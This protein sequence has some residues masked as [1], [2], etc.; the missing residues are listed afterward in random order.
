MI[1]IVFCFAYAC[2]FTWKSASNTLFDIQTKCSEQEYGNKTQYAKVL[3]MHEQYAL[4][5]MLM[6]CGFCQANILTISRHKM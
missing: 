3:I 6:I 2:I 4:I 1:I 5:E